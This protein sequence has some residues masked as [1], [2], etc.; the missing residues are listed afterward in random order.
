MRDIIKAFLTSRSIALAR[1]QKKRDLVGSNNI[2][3]FGRVSLFSL[4][5][6]SSREQCF[7]YRNKL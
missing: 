7:A 4:H 1:L 5:R 3:E 6:D 2:F